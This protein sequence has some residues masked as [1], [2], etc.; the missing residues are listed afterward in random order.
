MLEPGK[1]APTKRRSIVPIEPVI[2]DLSLDWR[3]PLSAVLP[4]LHGT[5][6][7]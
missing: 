4:T 7:R 6:L 1:I 5:R 3:F 2:Q